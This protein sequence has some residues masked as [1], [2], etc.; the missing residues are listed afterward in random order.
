[1]KSNRNQPCECG[2]GKKFKKC[3]GDAAEIA[4]DRKKAQQEMFEQM[5]RNREAREKE[6]IEKGH[7]PYR[8]NL[9]TTAVIAAALWNPSH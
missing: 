6:R 8:P 4:E 5:R 2:S 1:M 7:L 3:C 9:I